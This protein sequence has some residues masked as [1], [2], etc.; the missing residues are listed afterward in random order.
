[1]E[2]RFVK[3]LGIALIF[4]ILFAFGVKDYLIYNQVRSIPNQS[5]YSGIS[6]DEELLNKIKI[7]EASIQDRKMF[8]FNVPTDPLRQDPVIKDRLDRLQEWERMVANLVRLAATFVDE[9]NQKIAIIAYQGK[10]GYYHVGDVVA[11][12]RIDDIGE[13]V[14]VYTVGGVRSVMTV[15][16]IPPKPVDVVTG[17]DITEFNY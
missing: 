9:N 5:K 11:G 6:L 7:I 10:S 16:P 13:G 4:I 8:T 2:A 14:V 12:R 17:Q 1:M 15:Q 3:D